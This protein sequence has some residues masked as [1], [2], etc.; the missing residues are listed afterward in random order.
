MTQQTAPADVEE[1]YLEATH[2]IGE[3]L[4]RRFADAC[5]AHGIRFFLTSGTLLGAVRHEGWIPW[6]D[7]VDVVMFR[8][9]YERFRDVAA[10]HLPPDVAFSAREVRGDHITA[11]PRLLYLPSR[12]V[13]AGRSRSM[14]P[15]ET[16]HVPLDIF[17]LDHA[18]ANPIVRAAWSRLARWLDLAAVARY[19][20]LRDVL[21]E[22]TTAALRK[23]VE[24]VFVFL[25]RVLG[26]D[27][28]DDLRTR[29]VTTP[30]RWYASGPLVATNYS[31][32]EGRRMTF[33]REWY[34]PEGQLRFG[35]SPY[36][37]P[38]D[39]HSVLSRLF[40]PS[41]LTPPDERLRRPVHLRGGLHAELGGRSWSLGP[42]HAPRP[43]PLFDQTGEHGASFH[44]QVLWSLAARVTAA[45]L[46][47]LVLVLLARG[48]GPTMFAFVSSAYVALNVLVAVNGFGLLRQ[49]QVRRSRD[50]D[51]PALA[52]LFALRLWF[53]YASAGLWAVGCLVC[54]AVT[55]HE[56]FLA[57]LPATLWLLVEQT[58]QVWNGIS[59]V[60]GRA[61]HL[62]RSYL[63]RRLP[64]V[65]TLALALSL[66]THL[67]WAW[68][69]GLAVG[70]VLSYAQGVRT[71]DDWARVRWP[72]RSAIPRGVPL[73]LGYWW[74]LVGT[75][76]KDLDVALVASLSSLAGG[77]YA[78]PAR[79]ISPMNL[80]TLSAASVAFPRVARAGLNR[81]QL[82]RGLVLGI[83]P[84]VLVAV[85]VL[86]LSPLLPMLLG[87]AYRDSVP[88][89]QISCLTAV[90]TGVGTLAGALVQA[91]TSEDARV[92]GYLALGFAVAQLVAAGGGAVVGGAVGAASGVALVSVVSAC[93]MWTQAHRRVEP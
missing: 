86:S 78:F 6:D 37:V 38:G 93:T 91:L 31:T 67:V 55:R 46:Q 89:L 49:I 40:G 26:R 57:L 51:D 11:I 34:V 88:V 60:D 36:P 64:V 3:H 92:V 82:R 84:V 80:V 13:H 53:S 81:R 28:W 19:T 71:Q 20:T 61:Q 68:T 5:T 42:E 56:Y 90:M 30:G 72:R 74:G 32:P 29:L 75:Q 21:D 18:P 70:S 73:D 9:D 24:L 33:E 50:R 62:V 65:V 15:V 83:L 17:V 79:L 7:D 59:I 10:D 77:L 47:I 35:A 4:L 54:Y 48:L 16:R 58:T 45:V 85:G 69:L 41:Y 2:A 14:T 76:L 1:A 23:V 39:H 27:R 52:G 43:E 8:E 63:T 12:R 25:S 44:G 22:P 87:E 66:G